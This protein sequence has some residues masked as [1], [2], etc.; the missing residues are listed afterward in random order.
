MFNSNRFR[1]ISLLAG[2]FA[3]LYASLFLAL[4]LRDASLPSYKLWQAHIFPFFIINLLWIFAFYIA[5]FYDQIKKT[6]I[7]LDNVAKTIISGIIM[8]ILFF[9]FFPSVGITPKTV[10]AI[11]AITA[12]VLVWQWRRFFLKTLSLGNKI[13]VFF[14]EKEKTKELADFGNFLAQNQQ[15]G[16]EQTNNI[17]T[18]DIVVIVPH[19]IKTNSENARVLYGYVLEGKTVV[20]FDKI[21][22]SLTGKIPISLINETWFF[23]NLREL[24]NQFFERLKRGLDIF[25]AFLCVIPFLIVLPLV[26]TYLLFS[27]QYANDLV[28]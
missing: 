20:A 2:D 11:D 16:Y 18:A 5:G 7:Q 1:K 25:L 3:V 19:Q 28:L 15:L 8:A 9:Y 4:V 12:S 17:K 6:P 22:E 23:E 13:K 10:L 24:N 21:Y 14:F 26:Q 27:C